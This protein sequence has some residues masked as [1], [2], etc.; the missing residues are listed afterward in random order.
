MSDDWIH[1]VSTPAGYVAWRETARGVRRVALP[2]STAEQA[3]AAVGGGPAAPPPADHPLAGKLAAFY[4]GET[5]D[6]SS[7]RLDLPEPSEFQAAVRAV[8]CG[9]PRGGTMTYGEVARRAG[10]PGAARA[11][12]QVMA[13]NPVPPLIPCHRVQA[14]GGLGGFGGGLAMKRAMLDRETGG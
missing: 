6:F 12:G 3:L 8:V 2:R 4:G 5:V 10:R 9:I 1:I 7:V 14:A 11:V 13:R